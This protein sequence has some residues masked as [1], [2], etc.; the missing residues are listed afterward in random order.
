MGTMRLIGVKSASGSEGGGRPEE[1]G[2]SS[3]PSS[4][5][6]FAEDDGEE[7]T[8]VAPP[9]HL[10]E[11]EIH[12][13]QPGQVRVP[14]PER[15]GGHPSGD[16]DAD[17]F[18]EDA[19]E[20]EHALSR[21]PPDAHADKDGPSYQTSAPRSAIDGGWDDG[22]FQQ[23]KLQPKLDPAE[24]GMSPP[25]PPAR[26]TLSPLAPPLPP[27]M[28]FQVNPGDLSGQFQAVPYQ[29][30]GGLTGPYQVTGGYPMSGAFPT[31]TGAI[32]YIVQPV[33]TG[34]SASSRWTI[35]IVF[36][37]II[38][39]V[40]GVALGWLMFARE[41]ERASTQASA[42]PAASAGRPVEQAEPA[43]AAPSAAKS[44]AEPAPTAPAA[45]APTT[46]PAATAP[47]AATPPAT[48]PAAAATAPAQP[49]AA[50]AS[51]APNT[52]AAEIATLEHPQIARI[53]SPA[54]GDIASS[55]ISTP[56]NV[57]RGDRLFE[58]RRRRPGAANRE[59]LAA[60]VAELERL[61]KEDPVYEDFLARARSDYKK[62][63]GG[64][65]ISTAVK[66]PSDGFATASVG[67]GDRVTQGQALAVLSNASVWSARATVRG[68]AVTR[69]WTCAIVSSDG[70]SRA[71]CRIDQVT[72][73]ADGTEVVASVE[74]GLV[75]WLRRA[76]QKPRMMLDPP[77]GP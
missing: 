28:P 5:V 43:P 38:T 56:R 8:R 69:E 71:A 24:F 26:Q 35:A 29:T 46:P 23:P 41:P 48:P 42:P 64:G 12:G 49:A 37:L 45:P 20:I 73:T 75:P 2:T 7:Q 70:A 19:G 44:T 14:M 18:F 11:D 55:A 1:P 59:E 4:S 62:A 31:Y 13:R 33:V 6:D 51:P 34:P 30:M 67:R 77:R 50:A 25:P 27:A 32:P 15:G 10:L 63:Q 36:A 74:A 17:T 68:P 22:P 72:P 58:V 60:K 52:L 9:M 54:R 53:V 76:D 47:A 66:A 21:L 16:V 3:G 40:A 57:R 65:T 61:A 39:T